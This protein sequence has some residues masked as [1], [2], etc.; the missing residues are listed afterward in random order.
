[1]DDDLLNYLKK[2]QI[3]MIDKES[4]YIS[5][6][7]DGRK[8][9]P[10]GNGVSKKEINKTVTDYIDKYGYNEGDKFIIIY[11]SFIYKNFIYG[12]MFMGCEIR[13]INDKGCQ[14]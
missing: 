6:V 5:Y 1:M 13:V 14:L 8:L 12:P 7:K 11:Y 4:Q 10:I 3:K 2:I 9:I